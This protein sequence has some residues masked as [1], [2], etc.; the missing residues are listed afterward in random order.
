[1]DQGIEG[2]LCWMPLAR[3]QPRP[4]DS[5]RTARTPT[6]RKQHD[7]HGSSDPGGWDQDA[8]QSLFPGDRSQG[9][10]QVNSREALRQTPTFSSNAGDRWPMVRRMWACEIVNRFSHLTA[11]GTCSP[12]AR[13]SGVAGSMSS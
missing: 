13:P 11:D 12:E 6:A 5:P 10:R 3:K 7:I 1:M 2:P 9:L 4:L 8:S